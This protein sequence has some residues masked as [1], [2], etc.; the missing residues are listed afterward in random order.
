MLLAQ[1]VLP[2]IPVRGSW[3]MLCQSEVKANV[4]LAIVTCWHVV[5]QWQWLRSQGPSLHTPALLTSDFYL[6]GPI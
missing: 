1:M 2:L 4:P 6:P 3:D 5:V